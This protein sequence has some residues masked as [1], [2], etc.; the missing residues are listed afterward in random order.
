MCSAAL[1]VIVA[2]LAH[3]WSINPVFPSTFIVIYWMT[4]LALRLTQSIRTAR[5][6]VL[7]ALSERNSHSV[8][9]E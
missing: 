2:V 6:E 9:A 5:G 8:H 4:Y 7:N 1:T 3:G